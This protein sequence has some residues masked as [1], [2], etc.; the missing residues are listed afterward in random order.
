[1][2][3]CGGASRGSSVKG[4]G[5]G[6]WCQGRQLKGWWWWCKGEGLR[7]DLIWPTD[8]LSSKDNIDKVE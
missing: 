3:V 2:V 1:M 6:Q 5:G 8:P 7:G 4:G